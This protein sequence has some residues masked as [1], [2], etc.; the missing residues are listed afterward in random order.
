M[1]MADAR[2]VVRRRVRW[3]VDVWVRILAMW[4]E[5]LWAC[6][7]VFWIGGFSWISLFS[8]SDELLV[9]VVV[10]VVDD[11]DVDDVVGTIA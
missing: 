7:R 6:W 4:F 8:G 5:V 10:D 2:V 3:S 11:D 9:V 1:V